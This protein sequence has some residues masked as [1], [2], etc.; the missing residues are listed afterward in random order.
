MLADNIRETLKESHIK[1][2]GWIISG[3]VIAAGVAFMVKS[4][5]ELR[6]NFANYRIS[7]Y[8]LNDWKKK[9]PDLVIKEY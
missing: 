2:F 5:Y 6:N 9:N 8:V 4:Y 7:Q 1:T 3:V